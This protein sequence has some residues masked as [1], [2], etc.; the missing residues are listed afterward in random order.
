VARGL[1]LEKEK[2]TKEA[3]EAYLEAIRQDG[4]NVKAWHAWQAV[5]P[6]EAK[7]KAVQCFEQ[8]LRI[9]P[10]NE[11]LKKWLEEYIKN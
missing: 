11:E 1:E 4:E 7:E 5:L 2:K 6:D 8:E 9:T 3:E 10:E